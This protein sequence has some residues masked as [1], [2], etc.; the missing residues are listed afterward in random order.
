MKTWKNNESIRKLLF[1]FLISLLFFT[2]FLRPQYQNYQDNRILMEN[3]QKILKASKCE[4]SEE[5]Y[6]KELNHFEMELDLYRQLIPEQ[7]E[8]QLLYDGLKAVIEKSQGELMELS[9]ERDFIIENSDL[10]ALLD[11][12]EKID[13][14]DSKDKD[15][16]GIPIKIVVQ[17]DDESIKNLFKYL[18]DASPLMSIITF[19]LRE[20]MGKKQL[21]LEL[22]GYFFKEASH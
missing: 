2:L 3:K 18:E 10:L 8:Q 6:L 17:G 4:I 12:E 16:Y 14:I 9:F 19:Q 21:D 22:I 11:D 20:A 5:E 13:N 1:V 7:E 15:L